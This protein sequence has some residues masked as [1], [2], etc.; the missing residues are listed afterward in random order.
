MKIRRNSSNLKVLNYEIRLFK[1]FTFDRI[2][3]Y[4]DKNSNIISIEKYPIILIFDF[5]PD[6]ITFEF[7]KIWGSLIFRNIPSYREFFILN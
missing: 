3:V 2:K 5:L 4:F 7:I 6:E 1:S